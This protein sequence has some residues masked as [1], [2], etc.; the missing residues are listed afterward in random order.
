MNNIFKEIL[1]RKGILPNKLTVEMGNLIRNARNEANLSQAELAK[2][3]YTRQA[4]ISDIENGKR[5]ASSS[6]LMS[7]SYALNKPLLYFFP[8]TFITEDS[9]DKLPPLLKELVLQAKRLSRDDLKKVIT[10][11]RALADMD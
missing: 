7:L 3:V 6:E 4:T 1:G 2:L 5:E 10:Q 9:D 11:T 8:E